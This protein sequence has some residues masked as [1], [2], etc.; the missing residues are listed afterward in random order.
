MIEMKI[1]VHE[2]AH[3]VAGYLN[4]AAISKVTCNGAG[5]DS[6]TFMRH[7]GL[8]KDSITPGHPLTRQALLILLAG[9]AAEFKYTG[10]QDMACAV[11][12]VKLARA[13]L[14]LKGDEPLEDD[15]AFFQVLGKGAEQFVSHPIRWK[16]IQRFAEELQRQRQMTGQQAVIWINQAAETFSAVETLELLFPAD[17]LAGDHKPIYHHG[18]K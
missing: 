7:P 10:Q 2:A 9:P 3:T 14:K 8:W 13:C 4:G 12:D 15:A 18:G 17:G 6:T 5:V 11:H 16:M 1:A